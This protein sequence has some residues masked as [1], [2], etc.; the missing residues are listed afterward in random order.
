MD[1]WTENYYKI[2]ETKRQEISNSD[3]RFYNL[4]RLP[5]IAGKSMENSASCDVCR[6]NLAELDTL[7]AMLPQC[8]NDAAERKDFDNRK[9]AVEN[10]LKKVHHLRPAHYYYAFYSFL[11]LV[12]GL[13]TGSILSLLFSKNFNAD[14]PLLCSILGLFAGQITGKWKDRKGYKRRSQY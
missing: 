10:H 8:L 5:L 12:G 4:G 6:N 13:A 11:G 1:A 7:A 9:A 3:F 2:L 14:V